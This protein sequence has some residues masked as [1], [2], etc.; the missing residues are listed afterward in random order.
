MPFALA[1]SL[2]F[3]VVW[4]FWRGLSARP[5]QVMLALLGLIAGTALGGVLM[6]YFPA[7]MAGPLGAGLAAV[8]ALRGLGSRP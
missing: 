1:F 6:N 4:A 3:G 5:L 2:L 8:L 7:F